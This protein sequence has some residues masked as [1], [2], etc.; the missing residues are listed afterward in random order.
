[1]GL[2]QAGDG[3]TF[4]KPS[5]ALIY[6]SLR[7]AVFRLGQLLSRSVNTLRIADFFGSEAVYNTDLPAHALEA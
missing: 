7:G 3:D 4:L 6:A 1:M 2:F 5:L